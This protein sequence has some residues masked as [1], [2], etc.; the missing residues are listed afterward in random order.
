MNVFLQD[1]RANRKG[2]LI[3]AG[4]SVLLIAGVIG[5]YAGLSQNDLKINE[6]FAKMPR[7][8]QLLA[9]GGAFDLSSIGGFIGVTFGY[10][11]LIGSIYALTLGTN[12]ASREERDKTAEFLLSKPVERWQVMLAK[13]LSSFC[14]VLIFT[15]VAF[16]VSAAA[17]SCLEPD[18]GLTGSILLMSLGLLLVQCVFLGMGTFLASL[19]GRARHSG[20]VGMAF[21]FGTYLLSLA[22]Q[23]NE[24]LDFLR[25]LT[26]FAYFDLATTLKGNG[27][28]L[29]YVVLSAAIGILFAFAALI[30]G[31]KKDIRI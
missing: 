4:C 20:R 25:P 24:K 3:W 1:I 31:R 16:G 27:I 7:A 12:T 22:I 28:E 29:V 13:L 8:I 5:K 26:P 21:V 11:L 6:M 10:L 18:S 14:C 23:L 19:A 17:T 9:G 30:A 15:F 2:L